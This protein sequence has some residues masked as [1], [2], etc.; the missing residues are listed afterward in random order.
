MWIGNGRTVVPPIVQKKLAKSERPERCVVVS[1]SSLLTLRGGEE[2]R[3]GGTTVGDD[4]R[5][6]SELWYLRNIA[7]TVLRL[8]CLLYSTRLLFPCGLLRVATRC[9]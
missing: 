7:R 9:M 4:E 2:A 6:N 5:S 1:R 8:L 3:R